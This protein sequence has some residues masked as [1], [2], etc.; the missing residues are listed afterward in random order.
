MLWITLDWKSHVLSAQL[1]KANILSAKI[2]SLYPLC[3]NKRIKSGFFMILNYENFSKI[4]DETNK[5]NESVTKNTK[6]LFNG[7][8]TYGGVIMSLKRILNKN[9][10][11]H[12]KLN[13]MSVLLDSR[14]KT[15][16]D[17]FSDY[18]LSCSTRDNIDHFEPE[19]NKST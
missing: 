16:A 5:F 4:S 3:T 6:T 1:D 18:S 8:E 10:T 19:K 7:C 17:R 13:N 2:L 12:L 9:A 15:S 14:H 11:N